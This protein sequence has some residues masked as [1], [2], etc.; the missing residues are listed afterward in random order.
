[1]GLKR[2]SLESSRMDQ[3]QKSFI[4]GLATAAVFVLNWRKENSLAR[5]IIEEHGYCFQDLCDADVELRDL[6]QLKKLFTPSSQV[7][8]YRITFGRKYKGKYISQIPQIE[9]RG[10]LKWLEACAIREGSTVGN[11]VKLLTEAYKKY[12]KVDKI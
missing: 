8:D 9:L 5:E 1:M 12:Y 7:E 3:S 2:F 6:F 10:Y 11:Q 4:Q